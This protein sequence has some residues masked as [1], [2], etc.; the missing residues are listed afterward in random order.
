MK[1]TLFAITFLIRAGLSQ[2]KDDFSAFADALAQWGYDYYTWESI[3]VVSEDGYKTT[4]FH[5]VGDGQERES[6][7]TV[8]I[9]HD[10]FMDATNW[11]S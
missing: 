3:E 8:L 2:E 1:L 9:M 6:K 7:G 4:V 11:F 10:T 5:I